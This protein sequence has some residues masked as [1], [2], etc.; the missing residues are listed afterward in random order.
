MGK[1]KNVRVQNFVLKFK[2]SLFVVRVVILLCF[3]ICLCGCGSAEKSP[4]DTVT[5]DSDMVE[6]SIESKRAVFDGNYGDATTGSSATYYGVGRTLN[7]VD[8]EYIKVGAG[9]SKIFDVDKLLA[10]DWHKTF[11][12]D[13]DVKSVSGSSMEKYYANLSAQFN[14]SFDAKIG[15]GAFSVG[16]DSKFDFA[17]DAGFADTANEIFYTFSQTYAANLIEIDE[18]YNLSQFADILSVNVLN[19]ADKVQ[20]NKMSPAAFVYKYGTHVVLA[21]YYGGK[22]QC[23]YY[24]RN[25]EKRWDVNAEINYKNGISASF[26]K[27]FK[28]D[29]KT[30]FSIKTE[31]GLSSKSTLEN[32]TASGFGGANFKANSVAEFTANYGAWVDSLNA[33]KE[34]GNLVELPARSLVAIWDLF[35]DKFEVASDKIADYFDEVAADANCEFLSKYERHFT[36]D[37]DVG[38]TVDFERGFGTKSEPYV[39]TCKEQFLNINK[40]GRN[41]KCF[42]LECAVNLGIW[43]EPFEFSGTLDGNGNTISYTQTLHKTG[44]YSGGLFTRLVEAD[45]QRLKL[46]VKISRDK[47]DNGV[48]TVGAL[49]GI[50]SGECKI[51]Q[52]AVS[53]VISVGNYSGYDYVGGIVGKFTGGVIEQ[54]ANEAQVT[55][56]AR[57]AR[58]GGICGYACPSD[59]SV[60]ISD[61]LNIGNLKSSSAWTAAFGGR[62]SGGIVGQARGHNAFALSISRCY[63]DGTVKLEWTHNSGGGWRGVGGICG[64]I[65]NY[66]SQNISVNDCYWN[67]SKSETYGNNEAFN[68]NGLKNLVGAA[69]TNW[70][71]YIWKLDSSALPQL[72]WRL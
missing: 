26:G 53:G 43:N 27:L 36:H 15:Y 58:T 71:A 11:T 1:I 7:V 68:T 8:D 30:D 4:P 33:V 14:K 12:G 48:G 59:T 28:A 29:D 22:V 42:V 9:Y 16:V 40:D 2:I 32:F 54:C 13:M 69:Y 60:I 70:S 25:T 41:N 5:E 17:A 23:D 67:S 66:I 46:D 31:L 37:E 39:I 34:H 52:V 35:P 56:W 45:I 18:Y 24:L 38:D 57:N 3:I 61:C 64:D 6:M 72:L 19:D 50:T 51:N 20:S 63:N 65:E 44:N 62:T 49:T 10:L 21:G 55:N 47:D